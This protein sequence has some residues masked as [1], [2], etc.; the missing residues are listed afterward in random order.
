MNRASY[1]RQVG[2]LQALFSPPRPW[3]SVSMDFITSLLESQKYDAIFV[4]VGW[5][6]K[7]A[8]ILSI[9]EPQVPWR[10]QNSFSMH[11]GNTTGCRE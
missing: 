2:L 3:H 8:H 5:F 7:L 10:P 9:V 6:S 4:M 1:F 11:G